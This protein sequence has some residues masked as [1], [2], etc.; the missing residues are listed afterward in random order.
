[1]PLTPTPGSDAVA[2]GMPLVPGGGLASDIEEYINQTRDFIA[3]RTSNV[4]P[5]AK[6]GTGATTAAAAR[7]N[8][9]TPGWTDVAPKGAASAGGIARY[10]DAGRLQSVTPAGV[11]DVATVGWVETRVGGIQSGVPASGGTFTGQVYFPNASPATAG[12]A[13]AYLNNDGRL[14]RGASAAKYK[15]YISDFDPADLGDIFPQLTRYQMRQG[16][17]SWKYGYIADRMAEHPDQQRFVVYAF[18]PDENGVNV[19]TD[20]VESIDFIAL[21][22]AQNAQLKAQ[23]DRLNDRVAALEEAIGL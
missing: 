10:S 12:Y 9:D 3:Q 5:I 15:K 20:E 21:L 18:A 22:M 19:P 14:S 13:V 8:L 7:G 11:N 17:G 16:D 6:G 23:N 1:M 2:A 4:T